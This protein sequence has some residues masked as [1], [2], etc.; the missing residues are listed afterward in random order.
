MTQYTILNHLQVK[1]KSQAKVYCQMTELM[2]GTVKW[3][4]SL[5]TSG[6]KNKKLVKKMS[7]VYFMTQSVHKA[8]KWVWSSVLW[9]QSRPETFT[10]K[11]KKLVITDTQSKIIQNWLGQKLYFSNGQNYK[12][13]HANVLSWLGK[14]SSLLAVNTE[15]ICMKGL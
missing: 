11:D 2:A 7:K 15:N 6:C 3:Q 1:I 5:Q 12:Y 14:M 13:L 10:C 9:W 4:S 8:K